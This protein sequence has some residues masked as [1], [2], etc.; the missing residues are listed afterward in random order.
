MILLEKGIRVRVSNDNWQIEKRAKDKKNPE[1]GE[2]EES[3]TNQ[4]GFFS[5][6]NSLMKSYIDYKS[7]KFALSENYHTLKEIL[8][9]IEE[10]KKLID[11]VTK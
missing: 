2:M 4:T 11:K 5:S 7:K 3:W 10:T 6:F 8:L 9:S 1:T